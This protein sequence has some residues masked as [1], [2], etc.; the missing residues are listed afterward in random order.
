M[1]VSVGVRRAVTSHRIA[2]RGGGWAT[3]KTNAKSFEPT[4][5]AVADGLMCTIKVGWAGQEYAAQ[6]NPD[7]LA[8]QIRALRHLDYRHRF[9]KVTSELRLD[10]DRKQGVL[11]VSIEEGGPRGT[12]RTGTDDEIFVAVS[13]CEGGEGGGGAGA[14]HY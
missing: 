2:V 12:I 5:G 8:Y 6:F 13:R 7:I 4:P 14:L 10:P 11:F 1:I 3:V 9:V